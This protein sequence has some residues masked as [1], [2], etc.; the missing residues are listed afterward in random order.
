MHVSATGLNHPSRPSVTD[1]PGYT[2]RVNESSK[3]GV[4]AME[5]IIL[6]QKKSP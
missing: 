5:N 4:R 3:E 1:Y 2:K 6:L